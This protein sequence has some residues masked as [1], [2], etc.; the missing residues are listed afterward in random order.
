MV[1]EVEEEEEEEEEERRTVCTYM[2]LTWLN[3][4]YTYRVIPGHINHRNDPASVFLST[5]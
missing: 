5:H 1:D 3:I 2:W 4:M